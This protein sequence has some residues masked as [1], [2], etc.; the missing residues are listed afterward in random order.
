M[1]ERSFYYRYCIVIPNLKNNKMIEYLE[2]CLKANDFNIQT[3]TEKNKIYICLGQ[4]NEKKILE[5]AELLKIKKPKNNPEKVPNDSLLDKRILDLESKEYFK[6]K[7]YDK[8]LPNQEY[9]SLCKNNL[10]T[11]FHPKRL[12]NSLLCIQY[13]LPQFQT[14]QSKVCQ[15]NPH[16]V[17][18]SV[19]Q[20]DNHNQT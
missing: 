10:P 18:N 11:A 14:K 16:R 4:K 8:F 17:Y 19:R 7:N 15:S 20:T 2:E 3:F 1:E 12:S 13:F 9:E 5:Q 6:S